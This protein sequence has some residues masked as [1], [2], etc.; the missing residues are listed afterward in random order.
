M[1]VAICVVFPVVVSATIAV[2][3][4]VLVAVLK[5]A[6][7]VAVVDEYGLCSHEFVQLHIRPMQQPVLQVTTLPTR[8][9][10]VMSHA[11]C[12]YFRYFRH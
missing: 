4:D 8:C 6:V 10:P 9:D 2:V 1:L 5:T 7:V 12:L 11:S 3:F